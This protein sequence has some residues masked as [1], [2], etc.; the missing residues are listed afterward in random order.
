MYNKTKLLMHMTIHTGLST[1]FLKRVL[2]DLMNS[3]VKNN[4]NK[5]IKRLN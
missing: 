4:N 3:T 5:R 1:S 2:K